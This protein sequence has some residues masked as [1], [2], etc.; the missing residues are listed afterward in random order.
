MMEFKINV[1]WVNQKTASTWFGISERTL[2]NMRNQKVLTEGDCWRRKIPTNS[3]SHVLY[4]LENCE[5]KL[6]SYYK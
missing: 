2:L 3:N 5:N 6:T 4:Q 1:K